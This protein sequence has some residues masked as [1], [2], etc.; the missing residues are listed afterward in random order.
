VWTCGGREAPLP[1]RQHPD[2]LRSR[3]MA[4]V[5]IRRAPWPRRTVNLI[6]ATYA[7][8]PLARRHHH[9]R[10]AGTPSPR[11]RPHHMTSHRTPPTVTGNG[12][13]PHPQ[14]RMRRSSPIPV[15]RSLELDYRRQR[16]STSPATI[17]SRCGKEHGG[18]RAPRRFLIYNRRVNLGQFRF[19]YPSVQS[20]GLLPQLPQ[21]DLATL[22]AEVNLDAT[23]PVTRVLDDEHRLRAGGHSMSPPTR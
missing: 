6:H 5:D 17:P 22:T 9:R 19:V 15:L 14:V 7:R 20:V 8:M 4:T 16:R 10:G 1:W 18:R 3:Q 21:R 2:R 12:S 11:Q 13:V 23:E